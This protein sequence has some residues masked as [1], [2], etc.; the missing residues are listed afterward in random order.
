MC[1]GVFHCCLR[2]DAAAS[3]TIR[4]QSSLTGGDSHGVHFR[5]RVAALRA[6]IF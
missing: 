4:W 5:S 3:G 1:G 2:E 6:M